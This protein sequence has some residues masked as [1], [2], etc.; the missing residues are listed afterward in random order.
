MVPVWIFKLYTLKTQALLFGLNDI[1]V[2]IKK[3]I[4]SIGQKKG[5]TKTIPNNATK[6]AAINKNTPTLKP[7]M[8]ITGKRAG[9]GILAILF[10]SYI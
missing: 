7:L 6:A 1:N 10:F 5:T 3:M 9:N 2:M 8:N 4:S